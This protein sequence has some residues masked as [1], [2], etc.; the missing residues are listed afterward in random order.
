MGRMLKNH[1]PEP[2]DL[3]IMIFQESW[4]DP[5]LTGN[6][7]YEDSYGKFT[8]NDVPSGIELFDAIRCHLWGIQRGY[9]RVSY[10]WLSRPPIR[11]IHF[12][13][14]PGE[15][16]VEWKKCCKVHICDMNGNELEYDDL[17]KMVSGKFNRFDLSH[18]TQELMVKID[19]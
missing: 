5:R 8:L 12:Q 11:N 14:F 16:L 17:K 15:Q 19:K 6:D 10:H 2:N 3:V 9:F 1:L 13:K 18:L 7:Q 4:K